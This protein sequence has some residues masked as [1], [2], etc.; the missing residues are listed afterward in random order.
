[1]KYALA[2]GWLLALAGCGGS[3]HNA[4]SPGP[5]GCTLSESE[6][7]MLDAVNTA[8][9]STRRCGSGQYPATSPLRWSCP[10][11]RAARSH[12]ADMASHDFFSHTGSDGLDVGDRATAAGYA[13]RAIGENIAAGQLIVEEV[14]DEWLQSPGHCANIMSADFADFGAAAMEGHQGSQYR[15]YWTQVFGQSR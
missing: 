1:M 2:L 11:A 7:A 3:S 4:S 10:L 8:R 6:Q 12:S 14:M 9:A 15:V 13:W 5:G